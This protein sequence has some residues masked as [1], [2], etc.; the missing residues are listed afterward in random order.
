MKPEQWP[1][2]SYPTHRKCEGDETDYTCVAD[3][4]KSV[5]GQQTRQETNNQETNN[6]NNNLFQVSRSAANTLGL[7]KQV[8]TNGTWAADV[9]QIIIWLAKNIVN[10]ITEIMTC[11]KSPANAPGSCKQDDTNGVCWWHWTDHNVA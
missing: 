7:S 1:V 2:Q 6:Q 11:S 3:I 4:N 5:S 8:N 10:K 9:K